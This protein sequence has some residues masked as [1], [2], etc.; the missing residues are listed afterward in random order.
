MKPARAANAPGV[1]RPAAA[2]ST[3]LQAKANKGAQ[4]GRDANH[5][6]RL[7]ARPAGVRPPSTVQRLPSKPPEGSG[8]PPVDWSK[9]EELLATEDFGPGMHPDDFESEE[10][11]EPPPPP[12]P[13]EAVQPLM[14][15]GVIQAAK[16]RAL[17]GTATYIDRTGVRAKLNRRAPSKGKLG[18]YNTH[19]YGGRTYYHQ[20]DARGRITKYQGPLTYVQGGRVATIKTKNKRKTDQNG[21]LIAH[22]VGGD[23]HFALGYVAM[24]KQ[25]NSAGGDWG[26]MEGYIRSRLQ[27]TGIMVYMAVKPNY[28]S[29]TMHRPDS[30]R[31][32][33][34]FNRSPFKVTFNINTP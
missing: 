13:D 8:E 12:A 23:P 14:M 19:N 31:V 28:P 9:I 2:P 33:V 7:P 18:G 3:T 6:A 21:H 27:Q 15:P 34:Y 22:S 16:A 20:S 24:N 26:R 5:A 25:I 1:A 32:S 29:A 10:P 30:V 4:P 17:P 11:A